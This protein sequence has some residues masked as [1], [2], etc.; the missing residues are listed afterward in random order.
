MLSNAIGNALVGQHQTIT[1]PIIVFGNT[2]RAGT[3]QIMIP[4]GVMYFVVALSALNYMRY[5]R[6]NDTAGLAIAGL[7][8][9]FVPIVTI[10]VVNLVL[11]NMALAVEGIQAN[12][13]EGMAILR[14][15]WSEVHIASMLGVVARDVGMQ[16]VFAVLVGT[17]GGCLLL[18]FVSLLSSVTLLF[19]YAGAPALAFASVAAISS[20]QVEKSRTVLSYLLFAFLIVLAAVLLLN[21]LYIFVAHAKAAEVALLNHYREV[22]IVGDYIT[23]YTNQAQE[24]LQE[25]YGSVWNE[26]M[27]NEVPA[28][29][30]QDQGSEACSL[31]LSRQMAATAIPLFAA[32][33]FVWFITKLMR[34]VVNIVSAHPMQEEQ[35]QR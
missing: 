25:E 23:T 1:V 19:V 35:E 11:Y 5:R 8:G 7:M 10:H 12:Q 14:M 21:A 17:V 27:G 34:Y 2:F 31:L 28:D 13:V 20:A 18:V 15:S 6:P 29:M 16:A 26:Y 32:A 30:C 24:L 33:V 9:I 4:V 3:G 22:P